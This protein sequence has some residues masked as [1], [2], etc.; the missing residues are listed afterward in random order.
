MAVIRIFIAFETPP[1]IREIISS[2][3]THLQESHADVR[4]ES[5][6]KFHITIKFLGDL[7]EHRLP[8]IITLVENICR[9]YTPFGVIYKDLGTFPNRN[10]PKVVWI[11]CDNPDGTLGK[12]KIALDRD[13]ADEGFEIEQR[14]FHPH[15][16]L[17]R[18]KSSQ[19]VRNLTPML[20]NLTFE[21]QTTT[22]NEIVVM[23]S[24]L[25]PQG[26]VHTVLKKIHLG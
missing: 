3:A 5:P 9:Q 1:S 14:A 7:E 24:R 23:K 15:L 22:V 12:L 18:I 21:P 19:G 26:A 8:V 6:D 2:L 17:G 20:E 16:T 13:L 10:Q 25:Q 11:G 4:W